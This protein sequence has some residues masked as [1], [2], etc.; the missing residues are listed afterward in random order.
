ML[1][2][3]AS[4]LLVATLFA[5]AA[6]SAPK[7]KTGERV[8][9]KDTAEAKQLDLIL[10]QDPGLRELQK[11]GY[12][13]VALIADGT[14]RVVTYH[15]C[16]KLAARECSDTRPDASRPVV[17]LYTSTIGLNDPISF[18]GEFRLIYKEPA[19]L[20]PLAEIKP[21]AYKLYC[22][23]K[24]LLNPAPT[25]TAPSSAPKPALPPS[26]IGQFAEIGNHFGTLE[27][28]AQKGKT[29][30]HAWENKGSLWECTA[31]TKLV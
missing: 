18:N 14:I 23:V 7:P 16:G 17:V 3:I 11:A 10:S 15:I 1:K 5:L 12:T 13:P 22:Q 25:P 4:A 28:S 27:Y 26:Y 19:N 24:R 21:E 9:N 6:C 29:M 8:I 31:S 20:Q 2:R 30:T